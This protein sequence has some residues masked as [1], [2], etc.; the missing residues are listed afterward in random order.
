MEVGI[1]E[2]LLHLQNAITLAWREVW[3]DGAQFHLLS[4]DLISAEVIS[5]SRS[6]H[7]RSKWMEF[8]VKKRR[9]LLVSTKECERRENRLRKWRLALRITLTSFKNE[10]GRRIGP[11][12]LSLDW[13]W[14]EIE[15]ACEMCDCTG[16]H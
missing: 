9:E 11:P 6:V 16:L 2:G 10:G 8:C 5:R 12:H 7:N 3:T 4:Y 13:S 14:R 1:L 15:K